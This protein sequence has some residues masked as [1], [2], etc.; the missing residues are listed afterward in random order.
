LASRLTYAADR[1]NK[2][3][4]AGQR[5]LPSMRRLGQLAPGLDAAIEIR[6]NHRTYDA[7]KRVLD[8][9]VAGLALVIFA[10]VMVL[11]AIIIRWDSAGPA[12]FRQQRVGQGGRIFTFYKYRTM[13]VDA[14]ERFP[15][16]YDYGFSAEEWRTLFYKLPED[17][18][19][20]RF[21]QL[22][23]KTTLDELPNLFNVLQGDMSLVGP[24]PELPEYVRYYTDEQLAK[25]SVRSGVT[26]LAQ[27]SGRGMLSV[28]EQISADVEY[29]E[30]RSLWFDLKILFRTLQ[31]VVL[32]VGAF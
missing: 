32:R 28:Q 26:G 8:V 2:I 9:L 13:Y 19:L 4:R 27:T 21:G 31:M 25:F 15:E 22:L 17:P 23:R 11:I 12:V 6:S 16:L 10:P 18:R 24:R 20:T 14:R 29:V 30:N 3:P 5:T 7:T 1:Q